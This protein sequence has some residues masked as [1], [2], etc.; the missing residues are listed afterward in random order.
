METIKRHKNQVEHF[1]HKL[2]RI[3]PHSLLLAKMEKRKTHKKRSPDPRT[4]V[5]VPDKQ[6]FLPVMPQGADSAGTRSRSICGTGGQNGKERRRLTRVNQR[7]RTE[8]KAKAPLPAA[9]LSTAA[10]YLSVPSLDNDRRLTARYYYATHDTSYH[11]HPGGLI[12][13]QEARFSYDSRSPFSHLTH[14]PSF[15]LH[16]YSCSPHLG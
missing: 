6:W 13:L 8:S 12:I 16:T 1:D 11:D 2:T 7:L 9:S 4:L 15:C 14:P 5:A 3:P 10:L